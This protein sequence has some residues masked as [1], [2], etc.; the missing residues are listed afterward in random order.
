MGN[1]K[2]LQNFIKGA[3]NKGVTVRYY[4]LPDYD[5]Y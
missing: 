5:H 1:C 4:C 2:L 3:K